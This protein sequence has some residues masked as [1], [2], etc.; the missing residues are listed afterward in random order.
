MREIQ[1]S[2]PTTTHHHLVL[3]GAHEEIFKPATQYHCQWKLHLP[4]SSPGLLITNTLSGL[5]LYAD[6]QPG[7]RGRHLYNF[8]EYHRPEIQSIIQILSSIVGFAQLYVLTSMIKFSTRELLTRCEISLDRLKW[9]KSLST[10]S[11]D[12]SLPSWHLALGSLVCAL[13]MLPGALWTGA[14]TPNMLHHY[15]RSHI[16]VPRYDSDRDAQ[17]W[18]ATWK[19]MAPLD[20]VRLPWGNFSYTPA[21]YRGDAMINTAAG[22]L[23]DK[24]MS[25]RMPRSDQTGCSY[26]TRSYGVGSSIGLSR[27]DFSSD[28]QQLQNFHYKEVGYIVSVDC[29][30]NTSSQWVVAEPSDKKQPNRSDAANVYIAHG[31]T[32]DGALHEELGYSAMNDSNVVAINAH[33]D[34]N[35]T[36]NGTIV[37]A[38]GQGDYSI[39]NQTQCTVKFVPTEFEVFIVRQTRREATINTSFEGFYVFSMIIDEKV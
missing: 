34:M 28:S 10:K 7:Y 17:F 24:D 15:E 14:L 30:F 9:W 27:R 31:A 39:L 35:A 36:E 18:N 4:R 25:G 29:K 23:S 38:T 32:P 3:G 22:V 20:V 13:A 19:S 12:L 21:F 26:R 16:R 5:L 1:G 11:L 37:I 8:I 2:G 33:P 6:Y